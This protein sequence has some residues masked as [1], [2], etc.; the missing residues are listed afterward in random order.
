MGMKIQIRL[1]PR[2]CVVIQTEVG[3]NDHPVAMTKVK[4]TK[5]RRHKLFMTAAGGKQTCKHIQHTQLYLTQL[6][7]VRNC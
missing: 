2:S 5:L 6:V 4:L 7:A 1:L 3:G